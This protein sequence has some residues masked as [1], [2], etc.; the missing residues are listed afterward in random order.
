MAD[1]A[2]IMRASQFTLPLLVSHQRSEQAF[3]FQSAAQAMH[4]LACDRLQ[5][6]FFRVTVNHDMNAGAFFDAELSPH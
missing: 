2:R 1:G 4:V 5:D 6:D 3:A